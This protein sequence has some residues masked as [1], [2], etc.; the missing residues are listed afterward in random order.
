MRWKRWNF[1]L[2]N[3]VRNIGLSKG[4]APAHTGMPR[5][6]TTAFAFALRR[7]YSLPAAASLSIIVS[8]FQ[9]TFRDF[10][11]S[12]IARVGGLPTRAS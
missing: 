1:R 5:A 4:M 3:R 12:S 2:L 7:P 9:L 10:V 6:G 11:Q 8:Y